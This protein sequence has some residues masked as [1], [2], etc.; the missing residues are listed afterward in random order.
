MIK[1][2]WTRWRYTVLYVV[3]ALDEGSCGLRTDRIPEVVAVHIA[4]ARHIGQHVI[5]CRHT[6][7][8]IH[9]PLDL[10]DFGGIKNADLRRCRWAMPLCWILLPGLGNAG[11]A[12][13]QPR[14]DGVDAGLA[15]RRCR[16]TWR[17]RPG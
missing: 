4:A 5:E 6:M 8:G 17:I 7:I 15:V 9:R 16:I 10:V 1:P 2:E 11:L 12:C 13:A 14:S 3:E